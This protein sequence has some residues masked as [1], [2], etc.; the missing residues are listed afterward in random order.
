MT[1]EYPNFLIQIWIC[2]KSQYE[3]LAIDVCTW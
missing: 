2:V 1:N 3:D